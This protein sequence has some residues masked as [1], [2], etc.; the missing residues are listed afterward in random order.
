[1]FRNTI[2]LLF[3][4]FHGNRCMS[5][6]IWTAGPM[7][8]VNFGGEKTKASFAIE[9]A[10]WNFSH[11]PYSCDMAVEFEKQKV[12]LYAEAQTG[13]G[14]AGISCGPVV[15]FQTS[16]RKTKLGIQTSVWGNYYLGFDLRYRYIDDTSYLCPG[17]YVKAGF[18]GRDK[19]GKKIKASSSS[20]S[21]WDD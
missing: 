6:S 2:L 18:N 3:F 5:Q 20:F 14:L 8:H 16:E 15:E 1:M 11:F 19:N 7:L 21:D 4:L 12:R 17:V 13:I 9:F 10:Y